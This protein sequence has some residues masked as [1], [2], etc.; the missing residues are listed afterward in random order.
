MTRVLIV[1]EKFKDIKEEPRHSRILFEFMN[2]NFLSYISMRMFG[3]VYMTDYVEEFVKGRKLGPDAYLMNFAEFKEAL[4]RRT[5]IAKSALMDQNI[6]AGIGN[7]YSDEI[8][9]HAKIHPKIRIN[10]IPESKLKQ[11]W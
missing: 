3:R 11:N 10:E 8:L 2:S 4:H 6:I 9:F 5:T 7:I 1:M